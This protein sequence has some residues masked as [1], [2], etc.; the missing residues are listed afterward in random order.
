MTTTSHRGRLAGRFLKTLILAG[1]QPDAI[2]GYLDV[3]RWVDGGTVK[4]AIG[5]LVV[6]DVGGR[7]ALEVAHDFMTVV[8]SRSI[9]GQLIDRKLIRVIPDHTPLILQTTGAAAAWHAEGTAVALTGQVFE[10]V[11]RMDLMRVSAASVA[12]RDL[13]AAD[14][15]EERLLADLVSAVAEAIDG[16]F[17]DPSNS[18]SAVQPASVLFGAPSVNAS[19]A[20]AAAVVA[21]L[22]DLLDTFGG[23]LV[24]SFFVTTPALAARLVLLLPS[25]A[26]SLVPGQEHLLGRPLLTSDSV[27]TDTSGTI[28]A[29]VD[30]DRVEVAGMATAELDVSTE[31]TVEMT[32]TPTTSSVT[33]AQAQLVSLWQTNCAGLLGTAL[34][35]WRASG[36]CAFIGGANYG[37]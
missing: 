20:D 6:G 31:A 21:D 34:L 13:L 37:A 33:P 24:R 25:A 9:L 1:R 27:P 23:R 30:G 4:A 7:S 29:L 36:G 2:G 8:R 14:G 32:D 19:G 10:R 3:Q 11:P 22:G 18:G 12:T 17:I 16:A 35:N 5:S 15:F 28:V 26:I